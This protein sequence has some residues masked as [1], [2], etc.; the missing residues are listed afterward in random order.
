MQIQASS[1]RG[2]G[3]VNPNS[4]A[5]RSR[6]CLLRAVFMP[7]AVL[8][9]GA[10]AA[11]QSTIRVPA[12]QPTIQAA[13]DSAVNG[14]TVLV[15]PGTY[16]EAIDLQGKALDVRSEAGPA[17]TTLDGG[18]QPVYVVTMAS[19]EGPA[20]RLSGFTITGGRGR[21]FFSP[22]L[23]G[24]GGGIRIHGASPT[25]VDLVISGNSGLEGG[26]IA[27]RGGQPRIES[28]VFLGNEANNGAG[29]FSYLASPKLVNVTFSGNRALIGGGVFAAGNSIEVVGAE[30][31]GNEARDFGAGMYLNHLAADIS[32]LRADQ[33]G[34]IEQLPHGAISFSVFGG[35][36]L[37]ASATSGQIRD[38]IFS[39]NS[40]FAGAGVYLA[41]GSTVQLVNALVASN[42]AGLGGGAVYFNS[43][44][45]PLT[46]CTLVDNSPSGIYTTYASFPSLTNSILSGNGGPHGPNADIQGNGVTSVSYSVASSA[47]LWAVQVGA[48]VEIADPLLDG[49]FRP[50]A[51]SPAI[52]S[53]DNGALPANIATDLGG[54]PRFQDDPATPDVGVGAAPVVDM[55]AF[56]YQPPAPQAGRPPQRHCSAKLT[57]ALTLPRID[58]SGWPSL[59]AQGFSVR[60]E[61]ALAGRPAVLFHGAQASATPFHDG[62]LCTTTP[63]VRLPVVQT[64]ALGA[65]S[66]DIAL[67]AA[68]IGQ[69]RHYQWWFRDPSAASGDGL[70]DALAVRFHP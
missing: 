63:V 25:L 34:S 22:S 14:D 52:D 45:A 24:E 3:P 29:L 48:G 13:I 54:Q 61:H 51:G 30:C 28:T 17:A 31:V 44:S 40:A 21:T 47:L 64:S 26:G 38:S 55:G 53:G 6:A 1:F 58:Y 50:V 46:N 19:G 66:V 65:A 60:L 11:A 67:H 33:N 35:G 16:L 20:T 4:P 59:S 69:T 41:S 43:C 36:G 2:R 27:L 10:V 68:L 62:L 42:E 49:Q 18:G 7:T 57:S 5:A 37:Y 56:E 9:V 23:V 39:A 15:S 12:D 32:G 8:A 70:S